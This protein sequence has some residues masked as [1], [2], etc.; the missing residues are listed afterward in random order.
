WQTELRQ[1]QFDFLLI[2]MGS[3]I[4]HDLLDTIGMVDYSI[5][6]MSSDHVSIEKSNY[7]FKELV[8]YRFRNVELKYD[9]SY[10][11]QNLK[12][13]RK[14][15]LFTFRNL[16]LMTSSISPKNAAQVAEVING[17]KIGIVY[18]A[19]RSSS[20]KELASLYQFII[21][22]SFG[23][24][25]DFIGE[26]S[27]SDVVTTSIATM[28][29]VVTLEKNGE[30]VDALD[31]MASNMSQQLFQKKGINPKKKNRLDPFTYYEILGLDR[32]CSTLDINNQYEKLKKVLTIDNPMLRAVFDDEQLFVFNALLEAV[33]KQLSDHEIRKEYDMAMDQH[34]NSVEDSFPDIFLLSEIVKKY[35]RSKKGTAKLVKKDVFGREAER[36]GENVEEL[37]FVDVNKIFEKYKNENIVGAILKKIREESG[38]PV[39]SIVS[40]TKISH[41]IITAI[42]NDNYAQLHADIYVRGFLKNYCRAIKLNQDNTEKVVNDFIRAKNRTGRNEISLQTEGEN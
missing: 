12:R 27:Y 29:P 39:K 5:M 1:S 33:Y 17:L 38:I 4:D 13:T 21:R 20:E 10:T 19:I 8:N 14:D 3:R 40:S 30:F 37:D 28:K 23:V 36:K 15:I 32:G 18:N 9:L 25:A 11:V 22:S 7:F 6:F 42:E 26:L 35:Y 31:D 2:D 34:L 41:F 16:L 24:E